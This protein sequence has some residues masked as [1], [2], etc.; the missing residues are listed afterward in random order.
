MILIIAVP[1]PILQL[2]HYVLSCLCLKHSPHQEVN[3]AHAVRQLSSRP[4]IVE[5]RVEFTLGKPSLDVFRQNNGTLCLIPLR[6]QG[7]HVSGSMYAEVV[8]PFEKWP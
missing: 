3:V 4:G 6:L 7:K 5:A 2:A 1:L 8:L